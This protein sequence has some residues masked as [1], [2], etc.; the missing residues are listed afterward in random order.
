MRL[1]SGDT[2]LILVGLAERTSISFISCTGCAACLFFQLRLLMDQVS[3]AALGSKADRT[4]RNLDTS[5]E[6]QEELSP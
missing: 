6:P 5:L 1:L 2:D 4:T 3:G